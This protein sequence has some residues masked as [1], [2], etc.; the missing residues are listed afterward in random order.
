MN[1]IYM[2]IQNN[3]VNGIE[4]LERLGIVD[5]EDR[6]NVIMITL[7]SVVLKIN[8]SGDGYNWDGVGKDEFVELIMNQLLTM[9]YSYEMKKEIC[10]MFKILSE[11]GE[12]R[13]GI[14]E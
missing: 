8:D 10:G 9:D 4:L 7:I 14:V 6:L 5:W 1:K 13:R 2:D 12:D 3:M 11:Y